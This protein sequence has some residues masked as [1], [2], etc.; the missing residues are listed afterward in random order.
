MGVA[1]VLSLRVFPFPLTIILG[2]GY[3]REGEELVH[4]LSSALCLNIY[5]FHGFSYE[6]AKFLPG[7]LRDLIERLLFLFRKEELNLCCIGKLGTSYDTN[8]NI[9]L[10][11]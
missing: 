4:G 10:F 9:K 6:C 3:G 5:L 2:G 7:P 1:G 8:I 11:Y